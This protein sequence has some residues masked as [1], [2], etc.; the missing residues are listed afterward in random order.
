MTE[1]LRRDQSEA[2]KKIRLIVPAKPTP[3]R[4]PLQSTRP[5][6]YSSDHNNYSSLGS[7][8]ADSCNIARSGAVQQLDKQLPLLERDR[9][10]ALVEGEFELTRRLIEVKRRE[11]E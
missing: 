2:T 7:S 10:I 4:P 8:R 3:L 9:Q 5:T 11:Q 1:D 6:N